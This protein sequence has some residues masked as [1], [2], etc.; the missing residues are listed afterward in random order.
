M[1]LGEVV[2]Q[3]DLRASLEALRDRLAAEIDGAD[4]ARDVAALAL[5]LTDVLRQLDELPA[6][7]GEAVNALD[8]LR[9]R[10]ADREPNAG[11]KAGAGK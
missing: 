11:R 4:Q 10:R 6:A 8:E 1:S 5:R 7:Q 2:S 9:K 3:G